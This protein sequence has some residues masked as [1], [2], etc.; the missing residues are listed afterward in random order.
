MKGLVDEAGKIG[1]EKPKFG[2]TT[3]Q[4]SDGADNKTGAKILSTK[5]V[6]IQTQEM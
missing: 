1:V 6:V 3:L 4:V 5:G 2:D